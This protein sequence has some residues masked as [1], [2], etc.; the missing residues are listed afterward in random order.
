MATLTRFNEDELI[1]YERGADKFLYKQFVG[2]DLMEQDAF[3]TKRLIPSYVHFLVKSNPNSL[4]LEYVEGMYEHFDNK[5]YYEEGVANVRAA[6]SS[7][8][9]KEIKES[10][11]NLLVSIYHRI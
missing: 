4:I 11:E 5:E 3:Y 7:G 1:N 6:F 9:E 10:L 2:I 8:E